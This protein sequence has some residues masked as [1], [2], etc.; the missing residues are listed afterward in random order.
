M[1]SCFILL[2]TDW[3][4]TLHVLKHCNRNCLRTALCKYRSSPIY[5]LSL[6]S[7]AFNDKCVY[8]FL[9]TVTILHFTLEKWW[10]FGI[11]AE[12]VPLATWNW[13]LSKNVLR[14]DSIWKH[15]HCVFNVVH[16]ILYLGLFDWFRSAEGNPTEEGKRRHSPV[17]EIWYRVSC[18]S[19]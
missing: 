3:I 10:S 14:R 7:P 4:H 17:H 18:E 5:F 9:S 15:N 12:Y 13:I 11:V 2:I 6:S 16:T 1:S 8:P 19:P